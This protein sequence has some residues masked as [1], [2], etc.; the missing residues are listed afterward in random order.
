MGIWQ[1][2]DIV[3]AFEAI[4]SNSIHAIS[5]IVKDERYLQIDVRV[6]R[7]LRREERA[8]IV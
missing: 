6:Y 3:L 4:D 5:V 8:F 1:M 7:H 2:F